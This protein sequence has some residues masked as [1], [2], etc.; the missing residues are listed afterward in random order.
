M[1]L[2]VIC[3][4]LQGDAQMEK[5][6]RVHT[7]AP[8]LCLYRK[9]RVFQKAD[10][11][12]E[13]VSRLGQNLKTEEIP[14]VEMQIAD[15]AGTQFA[16]GNAI[17]FIG[18]M[19]IAVRAIAPFVRDKLTDSPVLVMDDAGRFVIPVLSGHVGGANELALLLAEEM[20]AVPVITTSTDVNHAFSVD[21]FAKKNSLRIVNR[22]GIAA[23]SSKILSGGC[24]T[25]GLADGI[26]ADRTSLEAF[27]ESHP[28]QIR[29]ADCCRTY[30][31]TEAGRYFD[32]ADADPVDVDPADADSVNSDPVDVWIRKPVGRTVKEPLSDGCRPEADVR[33][34]ANGVES[35]GPLLLLEYPELVLG[36]GCRRG[37]SGEE[38]R[39]F[40]QRCLEEIGR[41]WAE[42]RCIAS[43]DV[44][45]EEPGLLQLAKEEGIPLVTFSAE[46]LERVEGSFH[47]SDF[48][49]GVV[50]VGSVSE[51]AA[52]AACKKAGRLILPKQAE[53]GVTVAAA[54]YAGPLLF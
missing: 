53:N 48:V 36:I 29:L 20:S 38:I 35:N 28:G 30:G 42:V 24:V 1:K 44:K 46:E 9:G 34:R 26:E 54:V 39:A 51:R 40:A 25:I 10:R 16:A 4:T 6:K 19:G 17:L 14:Q 41:S 21:V 32:P 18:A 8:E 22:E 45:K 43:I 5:L 12:P 23:V 31:S 13:T 49:R 11:C 7:G 33:N 52:L 37:K 2:A 15:W 50:G 27:R 3:F 47:E